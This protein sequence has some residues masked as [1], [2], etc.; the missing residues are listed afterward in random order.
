ML[1]A[2]DLGD[3]TF[4]DALRDLMDPIWYALSDEEHETLNRRGEVLLAVLYPVTISLSKDIECSLPRRTG[5]L[6]QER[7]EPV[8]VTG[9]R[10][11]AALPA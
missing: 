10:M 2:A 5:A 11:G 8:D 6:Y 3:E 9:W 7:R 4:A 1:E